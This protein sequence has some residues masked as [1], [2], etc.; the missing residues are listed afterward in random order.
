MNLLA[1]R[2]I[3]QRYLAILDNDTESPLLLKELELICC[4]H[5]HVRIVR[6]RMIL[7]LHLIAYLHVFHQHVYGMGMWF[8]NAR[9]LCMGPRPY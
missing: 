4:C 8:F 6:L 1:V 5:T 3:G 9:V 2:S 7:I